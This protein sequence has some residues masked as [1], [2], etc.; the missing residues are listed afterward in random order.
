MRHVVGSLAVVLV[1]AGL[2]GCGALQDV[3]SV[4]RELSKNTGLGTDEDIAPGSSLTLPPG[5]SLRPPATGSAAAGNEST[6][7]RT[8]VILRTTEDGPATGPA[9]GKPGER[10]TGPSTGEREIMSRSG[11]R[12]DTANVVRRTVDIEAERRESGEK[13]F[14][15]RVLKYDP[16]AKPAA[17]DGTPARDA[18]GD[19]PV[20]KRKGE[21]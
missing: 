5:Y 15:D 18:T 4:T 12:S 14:T 17:E 16:K 20:I 6:A 3:Q 11:V 2:G 19:R 8:Q 13:G 1:A 21:L 7:R 10:T 9:R